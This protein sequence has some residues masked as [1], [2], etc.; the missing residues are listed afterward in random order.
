MKQMKPFLLLSAVFMLALSVTVAGPVFADDAN[1]GEIELPAG[2]DNDKSNLPGQLGADPDSFGATDA[3][4]PVSRS[5]EVE[6]AKK[7]GPWGG[8]LQSLWHFLTVIRSVDWFQW[9]R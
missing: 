4:V 5:S 1:D 9:V 8:F 2:G 3:S 7:S 6:P